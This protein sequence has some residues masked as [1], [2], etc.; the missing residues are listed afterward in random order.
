M[1]WCIERGAGGSSELIGG[2]GQSEMA[3]TFCC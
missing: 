1:I 3:V 2:S